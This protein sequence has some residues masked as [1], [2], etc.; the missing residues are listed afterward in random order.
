MRAVVD[1]QREKARW[2]REKSH[3]SQSLSLSHFSRVETSKIVGVGKK[4]I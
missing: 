4:I 1:E 2:Q 3:L